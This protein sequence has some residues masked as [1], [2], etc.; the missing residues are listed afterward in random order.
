MNIS[1]SITLF[2]K[3][4]S[5]LFIYFDEQHFGNIIY[6]CKLLNYGLLS[7]KNTIIKHNDFVLN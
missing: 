3:E 4:F 6:S 2:C 7:F 1:F 5:F